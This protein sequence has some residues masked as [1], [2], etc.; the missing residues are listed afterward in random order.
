VRREA[1]TTGEGE[2]EKRE[3]RKK[4]VKGGQEGVEGD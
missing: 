1:I 4:E 2:I 3:G